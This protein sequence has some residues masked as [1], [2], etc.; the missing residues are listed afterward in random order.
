MILHRTC[1]VPP[2][3]RG[4]MPLLLAAFCLWLLP[5]QARREPSGTLTLNDAL[6]R[7]FRDSP[8]LATLAAEV[9]LTE[10]DIV[11]AGLTPSPRLG[12]AVENIGPDGGDLLLRQTVRLSQALETGGKRRKRIAVARADQRLRM[13]D[14][15]A[16][17]IAVAV[18]VTSR[19]V[20]VAAEQ[21]R[22]AAA[23]DSTRIAG[24]T[25]AIIE[26]RVDAGLAPGAETAR[27][28]QRVVAADIALENARRALDAA[29]AALAAT[30]G[31]EEAGFQSVSG[32]LGDGDGVPAL[33]ELVAMLPETPAIARWRDET[34]R[35]ERAV[36]LE[37]ARAV[38]DVTVGAGIR[39]FPDAGD[40]ALLF[41][42][43]LPLP[44]RNRNQ[45]RAMRAARHIDKAHRQREETETLARQAL[46]EAYA[47]LTATGAEL[48]ALKLGSLAAA[49]RTLAAARANFTQG[50]DNYLEVLMAQDTV[51]AIERQMINA[52]ESYYQALARIDGLT[53]PAQLNH[54][55][56][57]RTVSRTSGQ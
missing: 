33:P 6:T 7:A 22:V 55:K 35:H 17:R 45:G 34:L 43:S 5:A 11:D 26:Q 9:H 1:N 3:C 47:R 48:D 27:A 37:R 56:R 31:A 21:D 28:A 19:F 44:I 15:E 4:A 32:E 40:A 12:A 51:V 39:H 24:K 41:E 16:Q 29:R 20:A 52:R 49:Q 25:L 46:A 2:S 57:T 30:W 54:S 18:A 50:R 38:P 8:V 13:W 42:V 36:E 53:A 14:Y 23:R 10:G